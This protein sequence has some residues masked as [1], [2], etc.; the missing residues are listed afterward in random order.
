MTNPLDQ[1]REANYLAMSPADRAEVA[2]HAYGLEWSECRKDP[3]YFIGTHCLT[4]DEHDH[5][6]PYKLPPD[7]DY[8]RYLVEEWYA[9][10][11]LLIPKSRQVMVSWGMV[12]CHLWWAMF[13]SG[14]LVFFQSKKEED[15]DKLVKRAF[16][17]WRRLPLWMQERCPAT[18]SYCNLK[19][20]GQDCLIQGIPQGEDQ[21]RSNTASAIFDDE[22]A[23]QPEFGSA[24]SAAQPAVE[25]GGRFTAAS[26]AKAG[27]FF[28]LCDAEV[29]PETTVTLIPSWSKKEGMVRWRTV[30]DWE[31]LQIHYSADPEKDEKWAAEASKKYRGGMEG[32]DWQ[33]E[34]EIDPGAKAGRKVFPEFSRTT[35]VI[36]WSELPAQWARFRGI[37]P[38]W[39]NP[40]A[41]EWVALDGDGCFYVEDG[42]YE[43]GRTVREVAGAIKARTGRHRIEF[44]KIGH[45]AFAKTQA[46]S[47]KTIADQFAEEGVYTDPS[48]IGTE[49]AI[50]IIAALLAI[51]DNGEPF[52]K[53]LDT[54][55]N[56]PLIHELENY[57]Y[58]ELS[59]QQSRTQN[60]KELPLKKDDHGIDALKH[61]VCNVPLDYLNIHGITD[62]LESIKVKTMS[63]QARDV[64]FS[65]SERWGAEDFWDG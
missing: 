6:Q 65:K 30:M 4:L 10:P 7:K 39:N 26:S 38:G 18:Y 2:R 17:V 12:L 44:T 40:C 63:R 49:S 8:F 9:N 19:F 64:A 16:G 1:L 33:A 29:V 11:R 23:F 56:Q 37:D 48:Y 46:A 20:T 50:Q 28:D 54:P 22:A 25:G 13:R 27:E 62:P 53:I 14:Q 57:R 59:E 47:G 41:V 42:Y 55:A 60:D 5:E 32:K 21:I 61:I 58:L 31:V 51:Q 36:P 45:D 3:W 52:L 35:H 34:M 15:A 43:R 24:F